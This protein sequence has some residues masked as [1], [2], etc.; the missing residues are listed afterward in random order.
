M[1]FLNN[2]EVF[3]KKQVFFQKRKISTAHVIITLIENIE[4]AIDNKLFVC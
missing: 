3:H 2:P 4:K 1:K